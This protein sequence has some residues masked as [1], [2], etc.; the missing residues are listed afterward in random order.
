VPDQ[1]GG[2]VDATIGDY[3]SPLTPT[4]Q[5]L[6][7]YRRPGQLRE[8]GCPRAGLCLRPTRRIRAVALSGTAHA[9]S[10]LTQARRAAHSRRG[11][12]VER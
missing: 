4:G 9:P 6:W 10:R 11:S 5:N 12:R 1:S 8:A 3:V 7:P 2:S